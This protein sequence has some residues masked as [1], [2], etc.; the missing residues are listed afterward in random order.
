MDGAVREIGFVAAGL[1]AGV[2]AGMGMG[3]GTLLIPALTL[4]FGVQQR[5]A[6]GVNTLAFIP[7]AMVALI[8]HY[9]AGRLEIRKSAATTIWGMIGAGLGS[10]GA[11]WMGEG[12]LKRVFGFFLTI[13]AV[14]EI[15]A[16]LTQQK[17]D[18]K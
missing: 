1:A 9:R 6:Q 14:K 8:I 3:G 18:R 16:A 7:A 2:I 13:I 15:C 10:L 11:G 12:L 4:L 5:A 17:I